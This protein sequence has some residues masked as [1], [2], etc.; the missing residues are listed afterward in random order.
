MKRVGKRGPMEGKRRLE[1]ALPAELVA[2]I[3]AL[4]GKRRRRR[5]VEEAL[6]AE[7]LRWAPE[8]WLAASPSFQGLTLEDTL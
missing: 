6:W 8:A 2:R 3:D 7:L 5:F 1:L 4:A